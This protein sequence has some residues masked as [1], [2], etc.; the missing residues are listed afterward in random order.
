M[1]LKVIIPLKTN[2][3][4]IKNKNLRLFYNNQSLFDIK[5]NQLLKV[6]KGKDILVSSENP[7]VEKLC[8]NYGFQF[9]LR[10]E[11]LTKTDAKEN[12]IVKNLVEA[13]DD[14]EADILWV[15]VTQPIFSEFSEIIKIWEKEKQNYDSLVVVKKVKHHLLNEKGNPINFNFGYWHKISQDLDDLYEITWSA[16]VMSRRLLNETYYQIGRKPY[17]YETNKPLIDINTIEEFELAKVIYSY[18]L[19]K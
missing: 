14:K 18:Y 15:Q 17:L 6:F 10:D 13:I 19:K 8:E 1:N 7:E 9:H 11:K 4:R 12:E 2:S 3:E 16:F 5:A